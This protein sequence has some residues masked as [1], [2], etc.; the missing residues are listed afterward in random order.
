MSGSTPS[1]NLMDPEVIQNPFPLY[2][3]AHAHGPVMEMPGSGIA[4]VMGYDLC[5]EA[6]ART[7]DFSNNF[8]AAL[9]GAL[10]ADPEVSAI[11]KQGW[12]QIDT[13]LTA[14]P[15]VHTRFRKLVNLAFSMPRVNALETG[16]R[17][18]VDA[19]IDGFI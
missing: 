5:V 2:Q 15:P 8:T 1:Q 16:M 17:A 3:W 13:L 9:S 14:D 19:L 18:K 10:S 6:T 12:P 7:G 4:V 11:L